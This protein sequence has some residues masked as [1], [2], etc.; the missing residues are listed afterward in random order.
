MAYLQI[1]LFALCLART[2][3]SA[4]A[5]QVPLP[6]PGVAFASPY[7]A[8]TSPYAAVGPA[9]PVRTAAPFAVRAAPAVAAPVVA[10]AP[11]VRAAPAAVVAPVAKVEELDA[12][13]QYQYAYSV[14]D[15]LT[16]D[17]KVQQEARD[18]G[19]VKGSY[20]LIEPDGARRTVNYYADPVNGFNA[21]VQR[22]L[23]AAVVPAA[24]AV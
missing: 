7:A 23:P 22:E 24:V 5:P 4:A 11:L 8:Y 9:L 14:Q 21:V 1:S 12:F 6:L 3:L 10:P 20:S 18:G 2:A 15:T 17:S 16:G 19:V 13:P